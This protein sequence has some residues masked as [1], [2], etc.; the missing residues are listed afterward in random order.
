[1]SRYRKD[2]RRF[3]MLN[4]MGAVA[5][6]AFVAVLPLCV[7]ADRYRWIPS[8]MLKPVFVCFGVLSLLFLAGCIAGVTYFRGPQCRQF[9]YRQHIW[10]FHSF[11]RSCL[12]CGLK[13]YEE[14]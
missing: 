2:W 11:G 13:L 8:G 3:R 14:K 10:S 5:F 9:F 1:M 6:Y 4:R 7:L 12:H